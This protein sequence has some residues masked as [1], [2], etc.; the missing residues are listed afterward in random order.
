MAYKFTYTS[1]FQ[2]HFKGLSAQEKRQLKNKLDMLA[3]NPF[4]PSLRTKR[5][6]GSTELFKCSVNF[7][8]RLNNSIRKNTYIFEKSV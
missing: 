3:D 8:M 6:Q 2:K 1:R 4:H 5:I 7:I